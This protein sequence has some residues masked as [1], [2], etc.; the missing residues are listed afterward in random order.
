[1]IPICVFTNPALRFVY[2]GY[3]GVLDHCFECTEERIQAYCC[4]VLFVQFEITQFKNKLLDCG[5]AAQ[6]QLHFT[7]FKQDLQ[8]QAKYYRA[9]TGHASAYIQRNEGPLEEQQWRLVVVSCTEGVIQEN[10]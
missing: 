5:H 10:M 6:W 2:V 3:C 4:S 1:M 9:S 8:T 7:V